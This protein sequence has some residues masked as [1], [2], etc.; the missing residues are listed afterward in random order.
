MQKTYHLAMDDGKRF[1]F[2]ADSAASAIGKALGEHLG[3]RVAECWVG[4]EQF[5]PRWKQT[6][7]F[8]RFEIPPHDPLF[9]KPRTTIRRQVRGEVQLPGMNDQNILS[10]SAYAKT[11]GRNQQD[12]K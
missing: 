11:H 2:P 10:E 6:E 7:A 4:M 5:D 8:M 12:S 9:K 3:H 1:D